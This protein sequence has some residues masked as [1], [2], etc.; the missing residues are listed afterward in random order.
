MKQLQT[1]CYSIRKAFTIYVLNPII[2]I[3]LYR[4][5]KLKHEAINNIT[6][7][8]VKTRI[9]ISESFENIIAFPPYYRHKAI[10][11]NVRGPARRPNG[12]RTHLIK[13]YN[14]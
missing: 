5:V 12:C 2:D 14:R 3:D 13:I 11:N 6:A 4:L 7:S 10:Q 9:H 1:P 8:S